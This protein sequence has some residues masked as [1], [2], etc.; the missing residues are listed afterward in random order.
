MKL[1]FGI[2]SLLVG[3]LFSFSAPAYAHDENKLNFK[4]VS[5]SSG[6]KIEVDLG[7]YVTFSWDAHHFDSCA[8]FTKDNDAA[9][10]DWHGNRKV[11]SS[12]EEKNKLRVLP[13]VSATYQLSCKKSFVFKGKSQTATQQ[14]AVSV[15][16]NDRQLN[17][18]LI[19]FFDESTSKTSKRLY[20]AV[21]RDPKFEN[22]S[23]KIET[24]KDEEEDTVKFPPSPLITTTYEASLESLASTKDIWN[25][26]TKIRPLKEKYSR[27][28]MRCNWKTSGVSK[29]ANLQTSTIGGPEYSA[30]YGMTLD[31]SADK[32][33]L[34]QGENVVNVQYGASGAAKD[35]NCKLTTTVTDQ[36]NVKNTVDTAVKIKGGET[37]SISKKF[38]SVKPRTDIALSCGSMKKSLTFKRA[39]TLDASK[40]A[41]VF[42]EGKQDGTD[43]DFR[44]AI[45]GLPKS[46]CKLVSKK[47]GIGKETVLK[48]ISIPPSVPVLPPGIPPLPVMQPDAS[49]LYSFNQTFN[50]LKLPDQA[51]F[52]QIV[53]DDI[54]DVG[55]VSSNAIAVYK[56]FSFF[57]S[58]DFGSTTNT[59]SVTVNTP[60][61]L[62]WNALSYED[63]DIKIKQK[64][65][66]IRSLEDTAL[67]SIDVALQGYQTVFPP[68]AETKYRLLC[69]FEITDKKTKIVKINQSKKLELKILGQ[70]PSPPTMELLTEQNADIAEDVRKK[71][72]TIQYFSFIVAGLAEVKL[73]GTREECKEPNTILQEG[74]SSLVDFYHKYRI[75]AVT[76]NVALPCLIKVR[77]KKGAATGNWIDYGY[78]LDVAFPS[79]PAV[80]NLTYGQTGKRPAGAEQK[81][82]FDINVYAT[83]SKG[84]AKTELTIDGD[85]ECQNAAV[86][87]SDISGKPAYEKRIQLIYRPSADISCTASIRS[88]LTGLSSDPVSYSLSVDEL[89]EFTSDSANRQAQIADENQSIIINQIVIDS[90]GAIASSQAPL[91]SDTAVN[92]T[93]NHPLTQD[94]DTLPGGNVLVSNSG[95]GLV[96]NTGAALVS[97]SGTGLVA[98]TG[99]GLQSRSRSV[100]SDKE[101]MG[102]QTSVKTCAGD[103]D[104]D[105]S[106]LVCL[107]DNGFKPKTL[108]LP[109]GTSLVFRN[110]SKN[111]MQINL[112]P[113][114]KMSVPLSGRVEYEKIINKTGKFIARNIPTGHKMTITILDS[115]QF[116]DLLKGNKASS[117]KKKP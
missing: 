20:W 98:N 74:G 111:K 107:F 8:A 28:V 99:A 25:S 71:P 69:K 36:N 102:K 47:D 53:C 44:I 19:K 3:V 15:Q 52:L 100:S 54:P 75:Q 64:E 73:D 104:K 32:T 58:T 79:K 70:P 49:G 110:E 113:I 5:P 97:N 62:G 61:Q 68:K 86:V 116:D 21:Y 16:V 57:A 78:V 29:S 30:T 34:L 95:T 65:C 45:R 40:K 94:G 96:Y 114:G 41:I 109:I 23:C 66:N 22:F 56:I 12:D 101:G 55:D 76:P 48:T 106:L 1:F 112:E 88:Y 82:S 77:Y 92:I 115:Q 90:F 7:A 51:N 108:Q 60:V 35:I 2:A 37:T 50:G 46:S 117:K 33:K 31:L 27:Y 83:D 11:L 59:L 26:W 63:D 13:F 4:A 24:Y 17:N 14:E 38:M 80:T 18:P 89:D 10:I 93:M 87:V 9:K 84:A 43:I 81:V 105:G 6:E 72:G 42:G 91:I 67:G 103:T 85:Q 39:L